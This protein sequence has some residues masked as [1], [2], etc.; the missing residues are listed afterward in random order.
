VPDP[1][2]EATLDAL[3]E[4]AYKIAISRGVAI[5]TPDGWKRWKRSVYVDTA[6]REG[7]GYLRSHYQRL[8][9]GSYEHKRV[10][11]AECAEPIIGSPYRK[12]GDDETAYCSYQCAGTRAMTLAEYLETLD[13]DE[14]SSFEKFLRRRR[15]GAA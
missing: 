4:E 14:R 2:I 1:R 11:C 7:P 6:R 13:A 15:E 3:V 10:E 12:E 9:L 5:T 8:G